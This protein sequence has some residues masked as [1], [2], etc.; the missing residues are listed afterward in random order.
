MLSI[1]AALGDDEAEDWARGLQLFI[2]DDALSM[3]AVIADDSVPA[4]PV[5]TEGKYIS[6][7]KRLQTVPFE[8]S[9]GVIGL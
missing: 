3:A 4:R 7:N 8:G 9:I 6:S 1:G 5:L 2:A